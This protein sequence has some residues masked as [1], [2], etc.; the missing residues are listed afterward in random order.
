MSVDIAALAGIER[1]TRTGAPA[2]ARS[3]SGSAPAG[4]DRLLGD[5]M[6]GTD[7]AE[8][9]RWSSHAAE[10]LA[11]R[12]IAVSPEMQARLQGAVD[13]LASKGARESLVLM[14][15]LAF[16]VSVTN[17]TVITAVGEDRMRDQI[18]TNIDSA[19]V[20]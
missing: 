10:R 12:R 3:A 9:L 14:D 4:F 18:F 20:R 8:A 19:A 13:D 15:G 11:Q 2:G 6:R 16:V 5:R 17:R 1:A 7:D